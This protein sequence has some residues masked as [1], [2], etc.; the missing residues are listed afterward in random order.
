MY[1]DS[2]PDF[3]KLV[4]SLNLK[5]IKEK[6]LHD[7]LLKFKVYFQLTE[8]DSIMQ[9]SDHKDTLF[10]T[11]SLPKLLEHVL[12]YQREKPSNRT[13]QRKLTR[14]QH[15]THQALVDLEE[16]ERKQ[17]EEMIPS[18]AKAKELL[19]AIEEAYT[20]QSMSINREWDFKYVREMMIERIGKA[21]TPQGIGQILIDIDAGFS[22]PFYL[23]MRKAKNEENDEEEDGGSEN[24]SGVDEGISY[25]DVIR[26][27]MQFIKYWPSKEDR[28]LWNEYVQFEIV[29]SEQPRLNSVFLA[30]KVLLKNNERFI[31]VTK[32]MQAKKKLKQSQPESRDSPHRP[33]QP[34]YSKPAQ[35]VSNIRL[36][37]PSRAPPTQ[38][39]S[40][41]AR[42]Q[43]D[44]L[45]RPRYR[46]ASDSDD[47]ATDQRKLQN[48]TVTLSRSERFQL[49]ELNKAPLPVKPSRSQRGASR[50]E[51]REEESSESEEEGE[52]SSDESEMSVE[53]SEHSKRKRGKQ[54][55]KKYPQHKRA[56]IRHRLLKMNK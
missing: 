21:E 8:T 2:Q 9:H 17:R 10:P 40:I 49:R 19:V 52:S 20:G 35:N 50:T 32:E 33:Q 47:S 45:T 31:E 1:L 29:N 44:G 16:I 3:Q 41:R 11:E 38:S 22:K 25:S 48:Q 27:P 5:G 18:L 23:R 24:E 6:A 28:M 34:D 51:Q 53:E 54:G 26:T 36:A 15:D 55:L 4:N 46:E 12:W 13:G 30:I 14:R 56:A 42:S 7:N 39:R 37:L 43:A